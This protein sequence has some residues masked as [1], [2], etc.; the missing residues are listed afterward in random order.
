MQFVL[1]HKSCLPQ[2]P[3]NSSGAESAVHVIWWGLRAGDSTDV[4]EETR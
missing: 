2:T 4:G 3:R 1:R